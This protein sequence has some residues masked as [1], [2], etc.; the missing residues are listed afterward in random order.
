MTNRKL[1]SAKKNAV[2]VPVTS[3][4]RTGA[5]HVPHFSYFF[6][7]KV[8]GR[9]SKLFFFANPPLE[10]TFLASFRIMTGMANEGGEWPEP[11]QRQSVFNDVFAAYREWKST[12][13]GVGGTQHW[14]RCDLEVIRV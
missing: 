3:P 7:L 5:G 11:G 9:R 6:R 14:Y 1:S 13:E 8:E 12:G 2:L 10:R 4:S